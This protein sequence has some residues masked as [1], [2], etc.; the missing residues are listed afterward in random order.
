M[1]IKINLKIF[2]WMVLFYFTKQIE[3]YAIFMLFAFV[4]EM[5]HL[6]AGTCLGLKPKKL[7][8]MPFGITI[9]FEEYEN[10]KKINTKKIIIALAGPITNF[11]I[12]GLTIITNFYF[13]NSRAENI[14]Y[15]NLLIGAFNLITIYPL[16]GGRI[17]RYILNIKI[18]L[19][20]SMQITNKISN[21][22]I[23][24]LTIISSITI[25]Y[26][27]NIAILMALM[28]LWYLVIKENKECKLK[29]KIYK[30]L[31]NQLYNR[32]NNGINEKNT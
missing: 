13:S 19:R 24:L 22:T 23:I 3:I 28:Y 10:I 5:G 27:K 8:I 16:D 21:I 9:T 31:E 25:L 1:Q 20:K 15:A 30:I 6:L 18:G 2:I 11:I 12:V 14:I 29:E 26:F 17:I 7:N 32:I 4:H